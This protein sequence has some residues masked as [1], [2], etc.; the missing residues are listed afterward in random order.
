MTEMK[1]KARPEYAAPALERALDILELLATRGEELTISEIGQGLGRSI[2]EVFRITVVMER[3][4]WLT[5]NLQSDKYGITYKML[6]VAF[7][8]TRAQGLANVAAPVMQAL[9]DIANQSSHLVIRVNGAG[10]VIH[11]QENA[12]PAGF[13]MR[14]GSVIDIVTSCSGQVLLAFKK[15][16]DH[17]EVVANLGLE[18]QRAEALIARLAHVRAQGYQ[19]QPSARTAGVTDISVPVFDFGGDVAAALT[20]PYLVMIDGSQTIGIK[21]A[22]DHLLTAG[23]KISKL[24]GAR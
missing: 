5:K 23:D 21:E 3:R 22:R 20:I 7:R 24:L 1:A 12:G 17:K 18:S 16:T 13:A 9:S 6:D 11:R 14:T 8:G 4:G 19:M 10:L 2:G 15:G